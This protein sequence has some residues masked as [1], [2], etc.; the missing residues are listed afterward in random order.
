MLRSLTWLGQNRQRCLKSVKQVHS[1]IWLNDNDWRPSEKPAAGDWGQVKLNSCRP[2]ALIIHVLLQS[3]SKRH[4]VSFILSRFLHT[5]SRGTLWAVS[6]RLWLCAAAGSA[7]LP[8]FDLDLNHT[9]GRSR[10]AAPMLSCFARK[11][12]VLS[13]TLGPIAS[14]VCTLCASKQIIN[15][16]FSPSGKK[17]NKKH[18]IINSFFCW[19]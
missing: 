17:N 18:S 7:S 9:H 11:P 5:T 4:Q 14:C 13:Y 19:I 8:A 16:L 6:W 3:R 15:D 2:A 12:H 10:G 1:L